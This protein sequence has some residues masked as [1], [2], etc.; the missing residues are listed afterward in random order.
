L[1]IFKSTLKLTKRL[2]T[3]PQKKNI[4]PILSA[5]RSN[6]D[7]FQLSQFAKSFLSIVKNCLILEIFIELMPK[8]RLAGLQ[9]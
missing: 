9:T 4:Y 6:A 7:S 5:Q 8:L 2:K 3:I 1:R